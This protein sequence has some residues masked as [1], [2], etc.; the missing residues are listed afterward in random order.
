MHRL[1]KR[2]GEIKIQYLSHKESLINSEKEYKDIKDKLQSEREYLDNKNKELDFYKEYVKAIYG[3][4]ASYVNV[5]KGTIED[6]NKVIQETGTPIQFDLPP[7]E[8]IKIDFN[9]FD[10]KRIDS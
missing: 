6:I 2:E 4:L 1:I 8:I 10:K 5:A 9:N 7:G 3:K